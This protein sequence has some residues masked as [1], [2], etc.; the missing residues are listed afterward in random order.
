MRLVR[1]EKVSIPSAI[2]RLQLG[3]G[4]RTAQRWRSRTRDR[5]A[6]EFLSRTVNPK[7]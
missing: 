7:H 4:V 3:I 5:N 2:A 6:H 1:E